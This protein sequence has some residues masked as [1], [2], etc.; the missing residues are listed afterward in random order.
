MEVPAMRRLLVLTALLVAGCASSGT[1]AAARGDVT[2]RVLSAPS[3]PVMRA[4]VPCPPRPVTGAQL[5]ALRGGD[6]VASTR[7]DAAG[8]FG[9][10]LPAGRYVIRATNAGAYASTAQ[11]QLVVRAE[12]TVTIRLVVDSGIR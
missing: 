6:E 12:T 2:G 10:T 4:G 8:R 11:R 1:H 9:L 3:C 5:V 7:T